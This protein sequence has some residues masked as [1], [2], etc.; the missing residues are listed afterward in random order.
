M[1]QASGEPCVESLSESYKCHVAEAVFYKK[2]NLKEFEKKVNAASLELCLRDTKLLKDRAQ[3]LALARE[4]VA[5]DGYNFKKGSSRS[6]AY[7]S[8]EGTKRPRYD[9]DAR[10][11][12]LKAISDELSDITRILAFKGKRLSQAEAAKNYKV[13]EQVTEEMMVLKGR[14]RE[15]DEEKRLFEKKAKSSYK[16]R[17]SRSKS[18]SLESD[19]GPSSSNSTLILSSGDSPVHLMSPISP[20]SSGSRI[21]PD[22][23][24][25]ETDL[26]LN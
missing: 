17:K 20:F 9:E 26:P 5:N 3:L 13:C 19:G 15:L 11:E 4:K 25:H 8:R 1:L 7:G 24:D 21:N 6:K 14:K 18:W 12:R 2:P 23:S 10:E 22:S 16:H